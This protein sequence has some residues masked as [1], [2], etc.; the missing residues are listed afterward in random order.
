MHLLSIH[1]QAKLPERNIFRA[2]H[3]GVWQDLLGD[4]ILQITYGRI[5]AQGTTKTYL[6]ASQEEA[7]H[8]VKRLLRRRRSSA[9]RIGC[10]Y[11]LI[12][13]KGQENVQDKRILIFPPNAER[14]ESFDN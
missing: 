5:G 12:E 8:Q 6:C 11:T 4:W 9:Q 3:L 10:E 13:M 2:Y 14:I 1:L 7:L